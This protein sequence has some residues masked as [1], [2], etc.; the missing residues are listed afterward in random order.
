MFTHRS[1]SSSTRRR[2]VRLSPIAEDSRLQP[3]VGVWAV[4]QSHSRGSG[5]HLLSVIALVGRYPTNKLMEPR[6]VLHRKNFTPTPQRDRRPSGI[7]P[8]FGGLFPSAGE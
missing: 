7:R 2:S 8:P 6:P 4:S 3:P 5:S 1:A